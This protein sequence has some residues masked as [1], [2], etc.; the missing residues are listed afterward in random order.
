MEDFQQNYIPNKSDLIVLNISGKKYIIAK[1]ILTHPSKK[2]SFLYNYFRDASIPNF[3]DL[4]N[5]NQYYFEKDNTF[6]DELI[7]WYKRDTIPSNC[8]RNK[9]LNYFLSWG[10]HL[11]FPFPNKPNIPSVIR[12]KIESYLDQVMQIALT[13]STTDHSYT[14]F[15]DKEA[16]SAL[17]QI[18]VNGNIVNIAFSNILS[19]AKE[20]F[21]QHFY[22]HSP[23]IQIKALHPHLQRLYLNLFPF[24]DKYHQVNLSDLTKVIEIFNPFYSGFYLFNVNK[25]NRDLAIEYLQ[26]NYFVSSSWIEDNLTCPGGA[27]GAAPVPAPVPAPPPA[28]PQPGG[29]APAQQCVLS[30]KSRLPKGIPY[31]NLSFCNICASAKHPPVHPPSQGKIFKLVINW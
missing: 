2:D 16:I 30:E 28:L 8:N 17:Y 23:N 13:C 25:D 12:Q 6:A 5:S 18:K 1:N 4:I 27:G 26:D 19:I 7:T 21:L 10:I 14:H 3:S 11:P 9:I 15:L 31:S 24:Y 29:L 22:N 20:E